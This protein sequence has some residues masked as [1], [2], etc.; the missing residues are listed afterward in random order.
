MI[1]IGKKQDAALK[2]AALNIANVFGALELQYGQK[3]V[4]EV[5][6]PNTGERFEME[7]VLRRSQG[8]KP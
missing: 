2:R 7:V 3:F 6:D 1:I 4:I 5:D 8:D